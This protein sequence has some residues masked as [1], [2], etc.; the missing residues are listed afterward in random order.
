MCTQMRVHYQKAQAIVD[1]GDPVLRF[2]QRNRSTLGQLSVRRSIDTDSEIHDASDTCYGITRR[3][4]FRR[5]NDLSI[6]GKPQGR[7]YKKS[8]LRVVSGNSATQSVQVDLNAQGMNI[9]AQPKPRNACLDRLEHSSPISSDI[10]GVSESMAVEL[11]V[12]FCEHDAMF[13]MKNTD[14]EDL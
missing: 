5:L 1:D 4:D 10:L 9:E 13:W 14:L 7:C 2:G 8:V 11:L 12:W 6:I 3:R